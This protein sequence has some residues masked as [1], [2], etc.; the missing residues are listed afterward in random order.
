MRSRQTSQCRGSEQLW[1][2]EP[3]SFIILE[4]DLKT[5]GGFCWP[6][7]PP[8]WTS[9]Q[10]PRGKQDEVDW[11][12]HGHRKP[13]WLFNNVP[14]CSGLNCLSSNQPL[15]VVQRLSQSSQ[16]S[17]PKRQHLKT[18][19][20][21]WWNSRLQRFQQQYIWAQIGLLRK[22]K[23]KKAVSAWKWRIKTFYL[24]YGEVGNGIDAAQWSNPYV[25]GENTRAPDGDK[26]LNTWRWRHVT[27]QHGSG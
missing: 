4:L 8:S 19:R 9:Q 25:L 16:H 27:V 6:Q 3:V 14:L 21:G 13:L 7:S 23:K 20:S 15:P 10:E 12:E 18:S 17:G 2:L 11:A 26:H 5:T 24:V 22:R 1:S